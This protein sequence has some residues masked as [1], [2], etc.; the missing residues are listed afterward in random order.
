MICT[1]QALV[2]AAFVTGQKAPVSGLYKFKRHIECTSILNC[3][4][5]VED[6]EIFLNQGDD[7]PSHWCCGAKVVWQLKQYL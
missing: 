3:S 7:F 4:A 6:F 2:G 5:P 1:N